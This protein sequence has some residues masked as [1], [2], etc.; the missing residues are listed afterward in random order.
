[1]ATGDSEFFF[2]GD[3]EFFLLADSELEE[4]VDASD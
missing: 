1:V 4:A 3:S 2:T